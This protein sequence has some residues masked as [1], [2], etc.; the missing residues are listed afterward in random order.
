MPAKIIGFVGSP[1]KGGNTDLLVQAV[2]R[3]AKDAGADASIY[4]LD[5]YSIG[6]CKACADCWKPDATGCVVKDDMQQFYDP[7]READAVVLGS[8]FWF[9]YMTGRAK[10]FLDRWFP[11]VGGPHRFANGKKF[12]LVL[13]LG[14]NEPQLYGPLA[15]WMAGV[16]RFAWPSSKTET[17]LAPGVMNSGDVEKHPEYLEQAYRLGKQAIED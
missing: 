15:R 17:L 8:P 6:D 2:L 16:F 14:R 12:I 4:Y 5:D 3:G 13:P 11:F 9:G 7:I 10:T 1:R